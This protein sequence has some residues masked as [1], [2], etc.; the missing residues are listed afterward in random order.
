M[1]LTAKNVHATRFA[2]VAVV[3]P[4]EFLTEPLPTKTRIL[5]H[6]LLPSNSETPE[7][8]RITPYF[9]LRDIIPS[10]VETRKLEKGK[11]K[12]KKK[13]LI[14]IDFGEGVEEI[15]GDGVWGEWEGCLRGL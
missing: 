5:V 8:F 10:I 3:N 2:F 13:P 12:I 6:V 1:H 15:D 7:G 11:R 14:V 4:F 9:R